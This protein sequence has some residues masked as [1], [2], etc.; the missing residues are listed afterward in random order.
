MTSIKQGHPQVTA[1]AK[2]G[3]SKRSDMEITRGRR[4]NPKL[5][6]GIG[7]PCADPVKSVWK[8][9]FERR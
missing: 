9:E 5:N 3:I 2:A 8:S 7:A 6:Q 4:V 1:A